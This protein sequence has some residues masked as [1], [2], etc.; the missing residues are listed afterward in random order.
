MVV[1]L[2]L[3]Q[4]APQLDKMVLRLGSQGLPQPGG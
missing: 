1:Q 3:G 2:P 4:F